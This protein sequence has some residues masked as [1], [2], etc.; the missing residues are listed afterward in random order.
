MATLEELTQRRDAILAQLA[1]PETMIAHGDKR[2]QLRD[3]AQAKQA[4][5]IINQE[6]AK[7]STPITSRQWAIQSSK[8]L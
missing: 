4:L 3:A 1:S 6:I 2:V 8:D 7:L 5:D